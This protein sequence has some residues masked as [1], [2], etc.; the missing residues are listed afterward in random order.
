MIDIRFSWVKISFFNR[1]CS[2]STHDNKCSWVKY[3]W[4]GSVSRKTRKLDPTKISRYRYHIFCYKWK[5]SYKKYITCNHSL[6]VTSA[7]RMFQ[8]GVD[9]Q[10]IMSRTGHRSIEGVWAY[11]RISDE[12]R[13]EL[14]HILL[15][16]ETELQK[17]HNM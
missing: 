12:Q 5:Q 11:K 13:T 16:M 3:S 7:T 10:L 15:Q 14:S 17:I 1:Y 6:C 4:N 8:G 2:N 9:E